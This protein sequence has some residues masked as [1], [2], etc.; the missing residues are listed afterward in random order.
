MKKIKMSALVLAICITCAVFAGC[1]GSPASSSGASGASVP[2]SDADGTG[3]V[4]EKVKLTAYISH[5]SNMDNFPMPVLDAL[6]EQAN[7]EIEWTVMNMGDWRTQKSVILA[8]SELPDLIFGCAMTDADVST[9]SFIDLAPYLDSA[10]NIK[11]FLEEN[12]DA[13]NMATD[14]GGAIYGLPGQP[15]LRPYSGDVLYVNQVWLDRLEMDVPKTTDDFLQMLIRFRDEDPNG[16]GQ[17]DE[18]G[19]SGY[20]GGGGTASVLSTAGELGWVFPAFGVVMNHSDTYCMVKNGVPEFQPITDNYRAAVEYIALLWEEN[21]MDHEF[22]TLDFNGCAAKYRSDPL[23]VGAGSGWTIGN[24]TGDNAQYYTM[25][26]PLIG[27]N[28]DQYWNSSDY[29]Y[30][31]NDNRAAITTSCKNVEAAMRFLDACYDEYMGLQLVYGSEGVAVGKDESGNPVFLETPEG[32]TD[33]EWSMMNSMGIGAGTW[34]SAEFENRITGDNANLDKLK[35]DR[36][37]SQWFLEESRMPYIT[38]DSQT[39]AD[40]SILQTDI[41]EYVLQ[42]LATFITEG[43]TDES[44]DAYVKQINAMGLDRLMKIYTDG[45]LSVA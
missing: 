9:G 21:L 42:S 39:L 5:I 37:Y 15:A 1:G 30:K 33:E 10:P 32:Y 14:A 27:P 44:W 35:A 7:V 40:L 4:G 28:G 8:Q 18:I 41:N 45:C 17:Q 19:F 29:F 34:C 12:P 13:R 31:L 3:G 23:T 25:I 36:F 24:N 11:R 26:E 20:A 38:Y 16:N 43:V 2:A 6:A 22:W